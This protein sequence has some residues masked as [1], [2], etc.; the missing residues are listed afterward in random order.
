MDAEGVHIGFQCVREIVKTI[1]GD[2]CMV[3]IFV[4]GVKNPSEES[5]T[6]ASSAEFV[7]VSRCSGR[8]GGREGSCAPLGVA[9]LPGS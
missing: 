3:R 5:S 4:S 6:L 8:V 9:N 2:I 1:E 7:Q